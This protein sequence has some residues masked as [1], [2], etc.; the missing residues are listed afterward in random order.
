MAALPSADAL[1][2]K[3]VAFLRYVAEEAINALFAVMDD[4]GGKKTDEEYKCAAVWAYEDASTALWAISRRAED[5]DVRPMEEILGLNEP[6][7]DIPAE[8]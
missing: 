4:M 7:P 3:S 5:R 8:R 2:P 1:D 6:P